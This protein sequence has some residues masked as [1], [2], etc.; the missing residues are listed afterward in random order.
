[1]ESRLETDAAGR[2]PA[3]ALIETLAEALLHPDI[4]VRVAATETLGHRRE[5]QATQLL[6]PL[7]LDRHELVRTSAA[8]SL[9]KLDWRP[10]TDSD[11]AALAVAQNQFEAALK[12]GA[13]A[14][15]ALLVPA[16]DAHVH[17]RLA[18]LESLAQISDPRTINLFIEALKDENEHVRCVAVQALSRIETSAS[19]NHVAG[20]ISDRSWAVRALALDAIGSLKSPEFLDQLRRAL[21]D[22]SQDLQ[23]RSAEI[24]IEMDDPRAIEILRE[25]AQDTDP[26]VA[27]AASTA[28][29]R[30]EDIR[31]EDSIPVPNAPKT[32][33]GSL[34]VLEAMLTASHP[35]LRQAAVEALGNCDNP[36]AVTALVTALMDTEDVVRA[37]AA[38][39]LSSLGWQPAT[40]DEKALLAVVRERWDEVVSLKENSVKPLLLVLHSEEPDIRA[41]AAVAL[42]RIRD[43]RAVEALVGMLDDKVKKVRNAAANSLRS[44]CWQPVTANQRARM[45]IELEAW[46][47]VSAQGGEA[48]DLMVQEAQE[49]SG[50]RSY[51][52]TIGHA[53]AAIADPASVRSLARHVRNGEVAKA[54]VAAL[55]RIMETCPRELDAVDLQEIARI[56]NIVQFQYGRE[57]QNDHVVRTGLKEVD[58]SVL[59][60][61]A[62]TELNLRKN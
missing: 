29:Q 24:L 36:A 61:L 5:S 49:N 18:A 28:L 59:R 31:K 17:N 2:P 21:R 23:Q 45:G 58:T 13:A 12:L 38:D 34:A 51:C 6:I 62:Q 10:A 60:D 41:Q 14:I 50:D 3:D 47:E 43:D 56:S 20:M 22:E 4:E 33:P 39:A 32:P 48:L 55:Q 25:G 42:G 30:L 16:R 11:R 7:L 40:P 35:D 1:M 15:D 9:R 37:A 52:E 57:K 27:A 54:A 8:Q 26:T 53:I 46:Q 19:S 44:F